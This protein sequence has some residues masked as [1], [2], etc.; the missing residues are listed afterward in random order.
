MCAG[1]GSA[2]AAVTRGAN[3]VAANQVSATAALKTRAR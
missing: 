2:A 3:G 1:L